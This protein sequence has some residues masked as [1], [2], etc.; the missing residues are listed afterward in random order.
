MSNTEQELQLVAFER[1][2]NRFARSQVTCP[3]LA[4]SLEALFAV[5]LASVAPPC[6][7]DVDY[8]VRAFEQEGQRA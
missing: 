8:V 1:E 7:F 3:V 2:L 5:A 6:E 4:P